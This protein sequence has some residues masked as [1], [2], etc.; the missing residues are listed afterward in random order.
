MPSQIS[1][2]GLQ[3]LGNSVTAVKDFL[4]KSYMQS[5]MSPSCQ[6]LG[7]SDSAIVRTGIRLLRIQQIAVIDEEMTSRLTTVYQ[8]M[9]SL[10]N[11]C[12][13]I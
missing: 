3:Q 9:N 10:V 7:V 5:F 12:L 4:S 6:V 1:T 11:S 13:L 8:T 2:T